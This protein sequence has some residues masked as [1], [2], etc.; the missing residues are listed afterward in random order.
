M[1]RSRHRYDSRQPAKRRHTRSPSP[2]QWNSGPRSRD[3]RRVE[4]ECSLRALLMDHQCNPPRQLVGEVLDKLCPHFFE[5]RPSSQSSQPTQQRSQAQSMEATPVRPV[6]MAPPTPVQKNVGSSQHAQFVVH[7]K[8]RLAVTTFSSTAQAAKHH[9]PQADYHLARRVLLSPESGPP[10]P[11]LHLQ[12]DPIP[13]LGKTYGSLSDFRYEDPAANEALD[14]YRISLFKLVSHQIKGIS[15][16]AILDKRGIPLHPVRYATAVLATQRLY[17]AVLN[18][19]HSSDVFTS[20]LSRFPRFIGFITGREVKFKEL[21]RTEQHLVT[22]QAKSYYLTDLKD[23]LWCV[24]DKFM[25][26]LLFFRAYATLMVHQSIAGY[27]CKD[28]DSDAFFQLPDN[29]MQD[30]PVFLREVGSNSFPESL[31]QA[32]TRIGLVFPEPPIA[33]PAPEDIMCPD[34][35]LPITP[36]ERRLMLSWFPTTVF[37]LEAYYQVKPHPQVQSKPLHPA[38]FF[39]RTATPAMVSTLRNELTP[40]SPLHALQLRMPSHELLLDNPSVVNPP[41]PSGPTKAERPTSEH[42]SLISAARILQVSQT[43]NKQLASSG[44]VDNS[45]QCSTQA[46]PPVSVGITASFRPSVDLDLSPSKAASELRAAVTTALSSPPHN[47]PH[48]MLKSSLA[49]DI[50]TDILTDDQPYSLINILKRQFTKASICWYTLMC[51]IRAAD[52]NTAVLVEGSWSTILDPHGWLATQLAASPLPQWITPVHRSTKAARVL[53]AHG[54]SLMVHPDV[55]KIQADLGIAEVRSDFHRIPSVAVAPP[56]RN[57]TFDMEGC[58]HLDPSTGVPMGLGQI[59]QQVNARIQYPLAQHQLRELQIVPLKLEELNRRGSSL[60]AIDTEHIEVKGSPK[61]IA[62]SIAVVDSQKRV[63][64]AQF[65]QPD[66]PLINPHT[67][68]SNI[69]RADLDRGVTWSQFRNDLRQLVN[70]RTLVFHDALADLAALRVIDDRKESNFAATIAEVQSRYKCII[71]DTMRDACV[72]SLM[73]MP[74]RVNSLRA[75][76]FQVLGKSIQHEATPH[77]PVVDARTTMDLWL[78]AHAHKYQSNSHELVV[79]PISFS[80]LCAY[81]KRMAGVQVPHLWTE[82]QSLNFQL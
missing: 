6:L 17:R 5:K 25:V 44:D 59:Y 70:G 49:D 37:C 46:L 21:N 76:A 81:A 18:S 9:S 20:Q 34:L 48:A 65:I 36:L 16:K 8:E 12:P 60:L 56:I 72:V 77:C 82:P 51:P 66:V 27:A 35:N 75:M 62:G 73:Q 53:L 78:K 68:H 31:V 50:K 63:V 32:S 2:E 26:R 43:V 71:Q 33:V 42:R 64:Y 15:P 40:R 80:K 30:F 52:E 45:V 22:L 61:M 74:K 38:E 39:A 7:P 69:R 14:H 29:H 41:Q 28:S 79:G 1:S 23:L 24:T 13:Q 47:W 19:Q 67:P 10:G 11:R 57:S 58:W 54:I 4:L 3:A 55:V